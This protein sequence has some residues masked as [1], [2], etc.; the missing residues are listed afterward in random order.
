MCN[1]KQVNK[2]G[3][4]RAL[5]HGNKSL[6]APLNTS[7]LGQ[8]PFAALNQLPYANVERQKNGFIYLIL[9]IILVVAAV[10]INWI[11]L[12]LELFYKCVK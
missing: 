3:C 5:T 8:L 6:S 1:L 9:F 7:R 12:E 2:I 10:L 11:G 4:D